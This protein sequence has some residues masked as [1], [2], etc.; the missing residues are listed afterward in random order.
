[1]SDIKYPEIEVELGDGNAVA[2][3]MTVKR[4]LNRAGVSFDE[5]TEFQ[6]EALSGDYNHVL[7]TCMEWVSVE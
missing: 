3:V 5:C 1:M 7:Q 2:I 4:A 6:N